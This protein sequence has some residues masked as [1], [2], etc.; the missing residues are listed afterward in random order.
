MTPINNYFVYCHKATRHVQ[1]CKYSTNGLELSTIN[2]YFNYCHST[3]IV[4]SGFKIFIL[5]FRFLILTVVAQH[6][7]LFSHTSF[8]GKTHH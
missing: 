4:M 8:D 2:N 5:D 6:S 3:I 7:F 1:F